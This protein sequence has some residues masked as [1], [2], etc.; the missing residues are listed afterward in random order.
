MG[1]ETDGLVGPGMMVDHQIAKG[2]MGGPLIHLPNGST[3]S[4]PAIA[5]GFDVSGVGG[6][7]EQHR[8]MVVAVLAGLLSPSRI[9]VL[10][11]RDG[12]Q[13]EM[14]CT[15]RQQLSDLGR[16]GALLHQ[17]VQDQ[18]AR[19]CLAAGKEAHHVFWQS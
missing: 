15:A 5:Q 6:V 14:V 1:A 19:L 9:Q 7:L 3:V 12:E 8:V 17:I 13:L 11:Q 2:S 4:Q 10:Q 16:L 18:E